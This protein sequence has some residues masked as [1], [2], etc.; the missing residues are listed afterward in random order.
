MNITVL[1]DGTESNETR[2]GTVRDIQYA[3][4]QCSISD[5][6]L[7]MA[8]DNVLN[9]SLQGVVDFA[10]NSGTSCIMCYEEHSLPALQK[11]GMITVDDKWRI[12]SYQEKPKEPE[13]YLAVPP[14]YYYRA[15]DLRRIPEALADGCGNDAPGS[16]AS[17]AQQ[18]NSGTCVSDAGKKI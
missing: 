1:D 17:L 18:K 8:G 4:E 14:F 5:E 15:K 13:G 7:V 3:V 9:F 2:L 12:L 11:T 6:C 16:F 10:V